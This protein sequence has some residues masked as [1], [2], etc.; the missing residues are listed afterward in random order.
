[1]ENSELIEK[2][3]RNEL[4][5]EERIEFDRRLATDNSFKETFDLETIIFKSLQYSIELERIKSYSF[6]PKAELEVGGV[7]NHKNSLWHASIAALGVWIVSNFVFAAL[8]PDDELLKWLGLI[9]AFVFSLVAII[10]QK[11]DFRFQYISTV[12]INGVLI[13][14]IS[15]G[16]DAINQGVSTNGKDIKAV[17]IPFTKASV[18][19]PT[20][21]LVDS[22]IKQKA[23]NEELKGYFESKLD[24]CS[25]LSSFNIV[26]IVVPSSALTVAGMSYKANVY[27]TIP[28]LLDGAEILVD[29]K[30]IAIEE[31][32][33]TGIKSGRIE[34]VAPLRGDGSEK[35][36]KLS[37]RLQI[38]LPGRQPISLNN[39]YEVAKPIV[40]FKNE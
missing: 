18:W 16:I 12:I 20:K 22:L 7:T 34:F 14:T 32:S 38:K 6:S 8:K 23:I 2:Y 19:W 11:R 10:V 4:L 36:S 39:K 25:E 40:K 9:L 13:F 15:S 33:V 1:M 26:P 37:Y 5:S 30:R 27:A 17:L 29:G 35:V 28:N 3:F 31:D 24:S 21:S